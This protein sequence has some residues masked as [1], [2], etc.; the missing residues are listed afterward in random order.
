MKIG[1]R[2]IKTGIAVTLSILISSLL[3]L[4]NPFFVVIAAVIAM[5]PTVSDSWKIGANR[6]IGT[7]IGIL[8][9]VLFIQI[10]FDNAI[11]TGLGI[12]ALISV[13]NHLKLQDSIVIATIIFAGVLFNTEGEYYDFALRR[14]LDTFIGIGV[15]LSI[16]FA[17]Y[18]PRY[19]VKAYFSIEKV[20]KESLGYIVNLIAFL[21]E[22]KEK[23]ISLL[24]AELRNLELELDQ[25]EKNLLLQLKDEKI[26][27]FRDFNSKKILSTTHKAKDILQHLHAIQEVL[28]KGID[29]EII[30]VIGDKLFKHKEMLKKIE[31]MVPDR[32][33]KNNRLQ[34]AFDELLSDMHHIKNWVIYQAN[35]NQYS[36]DEVISLLVFLYNLEE[37]LSV[38]CSILHEE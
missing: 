11:L 36:T 38:Y 24:D 10:P 29:K 34:K 26:T 16:N 17:I 2:T 18:P 35:L 7:V 32:G 9:G 33:L 3:G 13:M 23:N 22:E 5:Q 25:S 8:I 31:P 1:L 37:I 12:I 27:F 28:H 14:L 21:L 20:L 30:H 4:E 19:T 6:L 15:A